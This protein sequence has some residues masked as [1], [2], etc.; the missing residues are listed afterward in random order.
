[1]LLMKLYVMDEED[2]MS[3]VSTEHKTS[4]WISLNIQFIDFKVLYAF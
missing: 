3:A 1:M 4:C 2:K